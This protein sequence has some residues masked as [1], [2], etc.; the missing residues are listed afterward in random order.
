MLRKKDVFAAPVSC[1]PVA[2]TWVLAIGV[3][4]PA[5]ETWPEIVTAVPDVGGAEKAG[6]KVVFIVSAPPVNG[7]VGGEKNAVGAGEGKICTGILRLNEYVSP[8][9][10]MKE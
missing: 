10:N 9:P 2:L 3:L 1:E 6:L 8:V 5:M 4:V 7:I